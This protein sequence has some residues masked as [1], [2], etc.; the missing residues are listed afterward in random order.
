MR[1]LGRRLG[2]CLDDKRARGIDLDIAE[3][4]AENVA[5][6]ASIDASA[7]GER[8]LANV[9][10]RGDGG[11]DCFRAN[12]GVLVARQAEYLKRGSGEV[13]EGAHADGEVLGEEERGGGV[14]RGGGGDVDDAEG[15]AVA[16]KGGAAGLRER[17]GVLR[18]VEDVGGVVGAGVQM[19]ENAVEDVVREQQQ[20]RQGAEGG[21]RVRG[22]RRGLRGLRGRGWGGRGGWRGW[23]GG[24]RG[25]RRRREERFLTLCLAL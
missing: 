14:A 19:R 6:K 21:R 15:V 17:D 3:G 4:M 11:E 7:I 22:W 25:G 2:E 8:Q 23:R 20:R 1:Q 18:A 16:R 9:G 24:G 12:E 5:G 13:D 10:A